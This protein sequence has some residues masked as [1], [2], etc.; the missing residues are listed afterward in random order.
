MRLVGDSWTSLP[1]HLILAELKRRKED[2]ENKPECG[3]RNK[4]HYD[5]SAHVLALVLILV[6]STLGKS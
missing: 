4:G 2:V 3:S 1:T 6:L 5:M